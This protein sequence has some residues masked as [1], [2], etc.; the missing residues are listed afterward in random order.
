M[1]VACYNLKGGVGKTAAAVNLGWRAARSGWPTLLW[2]LDP[3]GAATYHLRVE[4][5]LPGGARGLSE[6]DLDLGDAIRGT[7][8]DN[9]DLLPS[10]FRLRSLDALLTEV[11]KG[12]RRLG[13]VLAPVRSD[14]ALVLVDCPPSI[15]RTLEAVIRMADAL[16]VPVIPTPLAVRTLDQVAAFAGER[17]VEGERL[18]PFFSMVDR[19]KAVHREIVASLPVRYPQMLSAS[20]PYAAEVERTSL[21]RVP[22]GVL[23]PGSP[24]DQAYD[25][26]WTE[27]RARLGR[28]GV[29]PRG[30]P[31]SG[32]SGGPPR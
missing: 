14:Y 24:A 6:A 1:I 11:R 10:D 15:G 25:A 26:L 2:D 16:L 20:V 27:L 32:T 23:A 19:R 31:F 12:R 9:L 3:Q 28:L 21:E 8:H 30:A 22:V 5:H 13:E 7:D 18:L 4:H 17:G 29:P